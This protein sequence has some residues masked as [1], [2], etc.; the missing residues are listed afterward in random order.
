MKRPRLQPRKSTSH[1]K[2]PAFMLGLVAVVCMAVLNSS[3]IDSLM[4]PFFASFKPLSFLGPAKYACS[5][6]AY[7]T[8]IVS[9]DP[10]LIYIHNFFNAADVAGVLSAGEHRF[11]P[12]TVYRNG[13]LVQNP[14]RTSSSAG[15]PV[16]DPAVAC[17]LERARQFLGSMLD[18]A[19]DEMGIPQLVRY[20]AGQHYDLHHDWLR[21]N[22]QAFDG[23]ARSFNRPASF[24]VI[25]QD[26]CTEGE[27]WFPFVEPV[28]PVRGER[29][30]EKIGDRVWRE[31][32]DGGLSFRPVAGNALF[33]V[34]LFANGTGD[35]RTVHAGLPVTAGSKIAL[36]IWPRKYWDNL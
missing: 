11:N 2:W 22:Q 19:A 18:P 26:D 35:E 13:Q 1:S 6:Q 3:T 5:P 23:S 10:L 30:S 17:V 21:D 27:T 20:T 24:F 9:L 8:E 36:N 16:D 34:N 29:D 7:T 32:K 28:R 12:S 15:L 14:Y 31:H 33:W 25:L 4:A